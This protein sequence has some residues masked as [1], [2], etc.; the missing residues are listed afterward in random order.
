MSNDKLCKRYMFNLETVVKGKAQCPIEGPPRMLYLRELLASIPQIFKGLV[1]DVV[2][3]SPDGCCQNCRAARPPAHPPATPTEARALLPTRLLPGAPAHLLP[4][5]PLHPVR[6]HTHRAPAPP[7]R[8]PPA[9]ARA[10]PNAYPRFPPSTG[11]S[12]LACAP[13]RDLKRCWLAKTA[14]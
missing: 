4:A 14:C 10:L 7:A 9:N 11:L 12:I 6:E 5:R 1:L 2:R 3:S 8:T 13:R